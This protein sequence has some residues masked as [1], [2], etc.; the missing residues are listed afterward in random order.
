MMKLLD[1][2]FRAHQ[3]KYQDILGMVKNAKFAEQ[4]IVFAIAIM[5][6]T[7]AIFITDY[8]KTEEHTLVHHA[9]QTVEI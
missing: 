8:L 5:D 7:D 3:I 6:A 2:V 4:E 1:K 9:T